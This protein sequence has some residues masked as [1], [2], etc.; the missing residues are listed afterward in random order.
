M[1]RLKSNLFALVLAGWV[2]AL[3]ASVRAEEVTVSCRHEEVFFPGDSNLAVIHLSQRPVTLGSDAVTSDGELLARG[4]DYVIDYKQGIVY[5]ARRAE[6]GTLLR[7]AY[8]VMPVPLRPV[9]QLREVTEGS[10]CLAA[11]RGTPVAVKKL[12]PAYDLKASGSK[13][14]S[15][16]TGSLTDF[17]MSQAFDLTIAGKVGEGVEI[18][19]IL[20]DKDMSLGQYGS[21]SRIGDL[22]RVFMEVKSPQA[23]ARVGDLEVNEAP[24]E[25]LSFRRDLTG[26]LGDASLGPERLVLAGAQSRSK[27][28]SVELVGREGLA[29]PYQVGG[30]AGEEAGLIAN[31]DKVWLDGETMKRGKTADY[32][33]DYDKGEIYFNPTRLVREGARIVVDYQSRADT[34]QRQFYFARSSLGVGGKANLAVS[35]FS[36]GATTASGEEGVDRVDVSMS[37]ASAEAGWTSGAHFVGLGSGDYIQV[38]ADTLVY[39]QYVGEGAGEYRVEF[40]YVGDGQGT[41]SYVLSPEWGREIHVYT[42]TGAYLDR[43]RQAPDIKAQVL[44]LNASAKPSNWLE[45]TSEFAQSTGHK[46][47][48]GGGWQMEDDKAYL[49]GL[50]GDR[51]L[52]RVAGRE[53]GT[54]GFAASRRWIGPGYLAVGR[55]DRPDVLERWAQDPGDGFEATNQISLSY[56]LG[57]VAR[58]S[59]EAGTM[60]TAAGDSRRNLFTMEL[61]DERLGLSASSEAADLA[62]SSGPRGVLRRSLSLRLPAG[63]VGL[64]LGGTS[65]LRKRL[66]SDQSCQTTAYFSRAGIDRVGTSV[67]LGLSVTTERRALAQQTLSRYSSALDGSLRFET[68]LG[69]RLALHGQVAHRRIEYAPAAGLD[70]GRT[71]S[72]DLGANL[73]DVLGISSLAAAYS[74]AN[75]LTSVYATELVRVGVGGDY[76]SLGNYVPGSG[77]HE[78]ARR[79]TGK[80]PVTR[81]KASLAVET[82]VKGKILLA[83]SLSTRSAVEVE[84]ESSK[85]NIGRL[86]LPNPSLVLR[87]G[88]VVYGRVQ[89]SEEVVLSR[90]KGV[91]VSM[92]GKAARSLD[93]RCADRTETERTAQVTARA[94]TTGLRLATLSVEAGLNSGKRRVETLSSAIAPSTAT[95]ALSVALERMFGGTLR[96]RVTASVESNRRS[97]PSSEITRVGL[98]PGFTAFF[99]P[100]RWDGGLGIKRLVRAEEASDFEKRSGNCLDWNSRVNL[101][102]G[103]YTSLSCEYVGRKYQGLSTIHNVK[104]SLSATF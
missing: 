94:A 62:S 11:E 103:R 97:E 93:S 74:L 96:S 59:F 40:T 56:R 45:V 95:R 51:P 54:V 41:Y 7:V 47:A 64:E 69:A 22:D 30:A 100:L 79:E 87:P 50:K 63:P 18:R 52:P 13:T 68:D 76:D 102:H 39:Y 70:A 81:V 92:T 36:E 53:A 60:G 14:I 15:L 73:R 83:R 21:T 104:A 16:E 3:S 49:V 43:V 27:Y 26:F 48:D 67:S 58:T 98:A 12:K 10:R 24:G 8:F 17:R 38:K 46:K 86:A 66:A 37:P 85:D 101:R 6:L 25:L 9:Y 82:G 72:A 19:G 32:V 90:A 75:T 89:V 20:S 33:I 80:Q 77:D 42:G 29:G 35:F 55:L 4:T 31:S 44:H 88:E 5:L 99:G 71:T 34:D 1:D 28:Q 78:M 84:G 2:C 65:D 23:Y 57:K 91:T 61:G